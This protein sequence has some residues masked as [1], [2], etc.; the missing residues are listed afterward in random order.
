MRK[1]DLSPNKTISVGNSVPA[2]DHY[3]T[4]FHSRVSQRSIKAQLTFL[5]QN[6][7]SQS[8]LKFM[9]GSAPAARQSPANPGSAR[10]A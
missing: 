4:N 3:L 5:E 8:A 1:S 10:C 2:F 9:E 7:A 6:P